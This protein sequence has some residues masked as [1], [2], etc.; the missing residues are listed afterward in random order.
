VTY[1]PPTDD[2]LTALATAHTNLML[3]ADSVAGEAARVDLVRSR[4]AQP[5]PPP[6]PP[7]PALPAVGVGGSGSFGSLSV[8]N[9]NAVLG[10]MRAA[11]ITHF[12]FDCPWSSVETSKGVYNLSVVVARA[13]RVLA[14]GLIPQ[15]LVGWT[16]SFYRQAGGT[17]GSNTAP[18]WSD[19]IVRNAWDAFLR[20]L[21]AA[22]VPL[23][24]RRFEIWNEPNGLF[25]QPVSPGVWADMVIAAHVVA[26][27]I[28]RHIVIVSGGVCPRPNTPPTSMDASAFYDAVLAFEPDFFDFVDEVGIHPYA[29]NHNKLLAGQF[30]TKHV[31]Y[32]QTL[33]PAEVP[34]CG[35]E[36]GWKSGPNT[37][38]ERALLYVDSLL[39]FPDQR[40]P[41]FLFSAFDFAEL[42]GL[43]KADFTPKPVY[44]AIKSLLA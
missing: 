15:V 11:G 10:L 44:D 42:Y 9:Q 40:A 27:D 30:W 14:A 19:Q 22:L 8:D 41:L 31:A 4:L 33:L 26:S 7:D 29:G 23:G 5:V 32:L 38:P 2:D 34:L 43:L 39:T 12:Q 25:M 1:T 16:P 37:E 6:P 36:H 18:R 35:T 3:A 21:F 24:V 20:A 17:A 13:K 28:S